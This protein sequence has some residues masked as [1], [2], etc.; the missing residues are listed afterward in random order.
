MNFKLFKN[1]RIKVKLHS[2]KMGY[3][4]TIWYKNLKSGIFQPKWLLK[5]RIGGFVDLRTIKNIDE[6]LKSSVR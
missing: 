2:P 5:K 3:Y 6:Y 4:H 1:G